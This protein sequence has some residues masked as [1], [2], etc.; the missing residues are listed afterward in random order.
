M[1][2]ELL[3]TLTIHPI[4]PSLRYFIEKSRLWLQYVNVQSWQTCFPEDWSRQGWQKM[5]QTLSRFLFAKLLTI[6]VYYFHFTSQLCTILCWS[7]TQ[8]PNEIHWRHNVKMG[9]NTL[10]GPVC[11]S[12]SYYRVIF[13]NFKMNITLKIKPTNVSLK[14]YCSFNF[15]SL[16]FYPEGFGQ[17]I[18]QF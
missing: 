14:S 17:K 7:V 18:I 4:W 1:W 9:I 13:F 3:F 16:S 2:Q 8:N 15:C 6:T 10:C 5:E 11:T 12:N